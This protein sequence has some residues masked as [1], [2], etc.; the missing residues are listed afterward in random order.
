M[1]YDSIALY[2]GNSSRELK[3]C[4]SS[5]KGRRSSSSYKPPKPVGRP[6]DALQSS[7]NYLIEAFCDKSK[8]HKANR[9]VP[10]TTEQEK[11][12]F[13]DSTHR[14]LI[15]LLLEKK[16]IERRQ[17]GRRF[18]VRLLI[19][20]KTFSA[21]AEKHF[22]DFSNPQQ[23][24]G[25]IQEK[26]FSSPNRLQQ[27][28][29][30]H[31]PHRDLLPPL[32]L[33]SHTVGS[34]PHPKRRPNGRNVSAMPKNFLKYDSTGIIN[35]LQKSSPAESYDVEQAWKSSRRGLHIICNI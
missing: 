6:D 3:S 20:F 32:T 13:S 33:K 12:S 25:S 11:Y 23:R 17:V 7:I 1:C 27:K 31:T 8:K 19:P 2:F 21:H 16:I 10:T 34:L 15:R 24:D 4:F 26:S 35:L 29:P 5:S 22:E 9:W 14:T 30:P 28:F 18:E